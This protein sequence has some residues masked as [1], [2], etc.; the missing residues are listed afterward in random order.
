MT[1]TSAAVLPLPADPPEA[2]AAVLRSVEAARGAWTTVA[3]D[4]AATAALLADGW[5]GPAAHACQTHLAADRRRW[6]AHADLAAG[7]AVHL[8][9]YLDLLVEARTRIGL[10]R[11]GS[12][13][14]PGE[15]CCRRCGQP[16][17]VRRGGESD[18]ADAGRHPQSARRRV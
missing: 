5:S 4:T 18:H 11:L 6:N 1:T 17:G 10:L 16:D 7:Q 8:G 13:G 2:V 15:P 3:D 14:D 9:R 12:G